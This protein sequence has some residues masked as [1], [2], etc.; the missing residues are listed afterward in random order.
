MTATNTNSHTTI[1]AHQ[2][3]GAAG[4]LSELETVDISPTWG[5]V[6]NVFMRFAMSK[7]VKA[8]HEMRGEVAKAFASAEALTALQGTLTSEQRSIFETTYRASAMR[9]GFVVQAGTGVLVPR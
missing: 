1:A 4:A 6:G 9:Q 2:P 8:L 7:E 5:D 3:V